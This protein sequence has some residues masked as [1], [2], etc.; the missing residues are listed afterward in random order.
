MKNIVGYERF[1]NETKDSKTEDSKSEETKSEEP[2]MGNEVKADEDL[3]DSTF[4]FLI[5]VLGYRNQLRMNHWQTEV[6]SEHK[7]TDDLME[8]LDEKVDEIG[9]AALGIFGRPKISTQNNEITNITNIATK[10][11]IDNIHRYLCEL[12]EQY[13]ETDYEGLI[14]LLGDFCAE[15]DKFKYLSTFSE[16]K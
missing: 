16:K 3:K 14:S 13:K 11:I 12:M 2:K 1:I 6:F 5:K 4:N 10:D 15:M 7:M 9:E 8:E